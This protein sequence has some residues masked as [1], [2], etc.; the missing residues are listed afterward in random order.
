M[1]SSNA[2]PSAVN[3]EVK[4]RYLATIRREFG[5][6]GSDPSHYYPNDYGCELLASSS[7]TIDDE[8]ET[9]DG[10][11]MWAGELRVGNKRLTV[12][13]RGDGGCNIYRAV[14]DRDSPEE[15]RSAA[16]RVEAELTELVHRG[17]DGLQGSD[18][19]D[20][21][22]SIVEVVAVV[23]RESNI[24]RRAEWFGAEQRSIYD[25]P[26]GQSPSPGIES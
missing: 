15:V 1:A 9:G 6:V 17:F 18:A 5:V 12:E 13:N 26:R 7:I 4:E 16:R 8:V 22:C 25:D 20:P 24:R 11:V 14:F 2:T 21:F 23:S 10:D 19:L 3:A